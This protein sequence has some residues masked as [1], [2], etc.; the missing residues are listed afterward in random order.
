MIE[1][2]TPR[3]GTADQLKAKKKLQRFLTYPSGWHFGEGIPFVQ[4]TLSNADQLIDL[5]INYGIEGTDAFP[6]VDGEIM[7]TLYHRRG[8]LYQEFTVEADGRIHFL[9][10][11]DGK[12]VLDQT[13]DMHAAKEHIRRLWRE[14]WR[15]SDSSTKIT[16]TR[17]DRSS[18]AWP[19][20][21]H[22][23]EAFPSLTESAP[24]RRVVK[25]A[26]TSEPTTTKGSPA[27]HPFF[28]PYQLPGFLRATA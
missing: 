19:S 16:T 24:K 25:Y 22:P 26:I 7:V 20:S 4:K 13:I 18:K 15:L 12:E 9:F 1:Q 6:G 10:E 14:Q 8:R 11:K 27:N 21:H 17:S 3:L 28:G 2:A 23:M 5:A